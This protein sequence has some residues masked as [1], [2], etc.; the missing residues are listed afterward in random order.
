MADLLSQEE[1]RLLL[2]TLPEEGEESFGGFST[3]E[4]LPR[5]QFEQ[6]PQDSKLDLKSLQGLFDGFAR[7]VNFFLPPMLRTA[8][9]VEL[10]SLDQLTY[11]EFVLSV[12]RP[13]A[14]SVL[15]LVPL[16]GLAVLEMN[17]SLVFALVERVLGGKGG[18]APGPRELTEIERSIV[19]RVAGLMLDALKEAWGSLTEFTP[20]LVQ[21][22]SDPY[23]LQVLAG[24][25]PMLLAAY[26]VQIAEAREVL[27][28]C[29][30][31]RL[32]T[33]LLAHRTRFAA[34]AEEPAAD[35]G[36]HAALAHQ[37]SDAPLR[38][39]AIIGEVQVTAGQLAH[40]QVGTVLPLKAF[41][42]LTLLVDGTPR[43]QARAA[44][45]E[46]RCVAQV[47]APWR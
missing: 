34:A 6:L 13:T 24:N 27:N 31:V 2:S 25:E 37:L 46:E 21:Q 15:E 35:P 4:E 36:A 29:L 8:A 23:V 3:E 14:L 20:R 18:A 12:H 39:E 17:P 10:A 30:P 44:R 38:L 43:L 9:R 45:R 32:L 33:L 41:D 5:Y 28:L 22:E 47:V 19:E 1:L 11:D 7:E 26:E 40:L 42:L 16:P